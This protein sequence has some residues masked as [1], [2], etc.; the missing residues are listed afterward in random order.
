VTEQMLTTSSLVQDLSARFQEPSWVHGIR[1]EAWVAYQQAQVPHLEKTDLRKRGWDFGPFP[2]E[3]STVIPEAQAY[4]D[5]AEGPAVFV[6]D[7]LVKQVRIPDALQEQ[8]IVFTDIHTALREHS[9]LVRQYFAT[10]VCSNENKWIS[11]NTAMFHG[12]VF[13]YV[14]RNIQIEKPFEL[15]HSDSSV[16]MGSFTRSLIVG[17]ELS[18]FSYSE[19]RF[20]TDDIKNGLVHSHVLEIVAKPDSHIKLGIVDELRKGPTNYVTRRAHV[21][22]DAHV[23][24]VSGDIGDGFS[25]AL[26]ESVMKGPGSKSTT[27]HVGLGFGRQRLDMTTS[28]VHEGRYSESDITMHGIIRDKAYSLYRSSTHILK[29]A[30]MAGSEQNDRMIVFDKAS[31]A[32]A[33]PM[34]LIDENDVERCGHAA[35]VGKLD[36]NQIYYLMSRGIS[37]VKA[38]EMILWG[39]L[40]QTVASLPT[41]GAKKVLTSRIERELNR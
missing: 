3:I 27:R 11:L 35:S 34:L 4:F 6:V 31:R 32:D 9:D 7:G 30:V 12:G 22:K 29:G 23:E 21:G 5:N 36:P 39:Y 17:S 37:E 28:M 38:T 13:L 1:E 25:V 2:S 26:L 40:S 19:V 10:V 41:E 15:V 20:M 33:I 8:G 18:D 14:P 24:W 16:G